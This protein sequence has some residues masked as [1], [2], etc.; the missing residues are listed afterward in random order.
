M[1]FKRKNVSRVLIS[2]F[3]YLT[4]FLTT[5]SEILICISHLL[6]P[7]WKFYS[8]LS[9]SLLILLFLC[10]YMAIPIFWLPKSK[11]G[12]L[13]WLP[14][15]YHTPLKWANSIDTCLKLYPESKCCLS[16]TAQTH[17]LRLLLEVSNWLILQFC[18]CSPLNGHSNHV[19]T[20][21]ISY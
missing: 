4:T 12:S 14:S 17:F 16:S 2:R 1:D 7:K 5:L 10:Q 9:P 18:C 21:V 15:F 20:Y 13:S 6:S 8:P 11:S 3:K 19:K